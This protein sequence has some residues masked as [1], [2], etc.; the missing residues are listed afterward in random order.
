MWARF[1]TLPSQDRI[2]TL[3]LTSRS[4][5]K[6]SQQAAAAKKTPLVLV[7][8]FGAGVGLWVRNLD[9]L[10]SGPRALHAFDLLGFGRSSR[11]AFPGRDA[12]RAEEQFVS[13]IEQWREA[14]GLESMHLILVEPWGYPDRAQSLAAEAQ[15][16]EEAK[17]PSLPLWV[18]AAVAVLRFFN[19]LAVIRAAGPWGPGLVSRFRH[20][21][22]S[23]FEDLFDDDTMTQYIYHCNAQ[24]PS[25]EVGYWAM[26][27]SLTWAKRPMLHRVDQLPASL[28]VTM[29]YGDRS[30]MNASSG[31]QAAK[32]RGEAYTRVVLIS[33]ASHHVNTDQSEVFNK[34]VEQICDSVD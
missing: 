13:S 11:P 32:I 21:F 1:V 16:V 10:S 4:P 34:H 5:P 6:P 26:M 29:L 17:R 22:K 30:W 20:D 3:S 8:G 19:P 2:W 31:H 9:P 18:K 25:G 23:K 33:N 24:A 7:H 15:G 14:M 27:Q 12:V 28:P